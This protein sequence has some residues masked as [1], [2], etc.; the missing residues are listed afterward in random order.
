MAGSDVLDRAGWLHH[1]NCWG[2]GPDNRDGLRLRPEL[3]DDGAFHLAF[4]ADDRL[5]GPPGRVHGGLLAVPM[6]CLGSWAAIH[7][8]RERAA[9]EGRDPST[10]VALTAGYE[11]RLHASTPTGGLLRLRADVVEM[12]GRRVRVRVE[13][14][15]DAEVTA[16]L[17]GLFV[18][19]G[20][21]V[22]GTVGD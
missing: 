20:T 16:H 8:V 17:D 7:A 14:R 22:G 3:G 2:C 10:V 6:D 15:H 4:T 11:V 21:D 13:V 12:T 5:H 18:E 9:A 19:V 1:R